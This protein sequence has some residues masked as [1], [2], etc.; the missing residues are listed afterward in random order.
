[1]D[2]VLK[3][4]LDASS[5]LSNQILLREVNFIPDEDFKLLGNLLI[6]RR[7]LINFKSLI[8]KKV[9]KRSV[10]SDFAKRS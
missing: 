3:A 9:V 1:M 2:G 6:F 10:L 5:A 7:F 8:G 4:N